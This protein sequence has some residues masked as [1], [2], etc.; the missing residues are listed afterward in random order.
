MKSSRG[1]P[2]HRFRSAAIIASVL[3]FAL[4]SR[5][6][7]ALTELLHDAEPNDAP[8]QAVPLDLPTEKDVVRVLGELKGQDQDGYL[9]VVGD[10][11]A[12]RRFDLLLTGRAGALTKLDVFEFTEFVDARGEIPEALPSK[13]ASVFQLSTQ[14]GVRPAAAAGLLLAPGTYVLGVS[15]SGGEGSYELEIDQTDNQSVAVIDMTEN[16]AED[17]RRISMRGRSTL[18][19]GGETFG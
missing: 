4:A 3:L 18:F 8:H 5:S 7:A 9:L 13:P 1:F 16:S 19:S 12:G 2:S 14:Q 17:P 15:H 6:A 11:H 10:E